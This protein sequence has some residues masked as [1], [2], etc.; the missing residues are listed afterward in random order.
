MQ[1]NFLQPWPAV[2]SKLIGRVYRRY[3]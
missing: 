3:S 1:K 2:Q